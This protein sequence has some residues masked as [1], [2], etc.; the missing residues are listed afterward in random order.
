MYA[1]SLVKVPYVY[2]ML[3]TVSDFEYNKMH[4]DA[5]G[6]PLYDEAGQPLFE[7]AHPNLDEEGR[8]VYLPVKDFDI[9]IWKQLLY[10]RDKWVSPVMKTMIEYCS[11]YSSLI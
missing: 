10:H 9:D 11:K 4:F 5:E 3:K 6:N 1:A 8:I 7:G 2:T